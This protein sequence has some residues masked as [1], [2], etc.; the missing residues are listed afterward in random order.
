MAKTFIQDAINKTL[1]P[2]E[3]SKKS[4]QRV[5]EQEIE[6][7]RNELYNMI[8]GNEEAYKDQID[9]RIN[10]IIERLHD[11][12]KSEI[13]DDIEIN[14]HN[15]IP[16][17]TALNKKYNAGKVVGITS[18]LAV[19]LAVTTVACGSK[20][21]TTVE[22]PVE[23]I[24]SIDNEDVSVEIDENQLAAEQ[25]LKQFSTKS[26]ENV[27][28]AIN[29]LLANGIRVVDKD[30][31]EE[32]QKDLISSEWIQYY[33]VA[34][35]DD[36]TTLEYAN[37]MKE[38]PG[39]VLDNDDLIYDFRNMNV[40]MKEQMLVSMPDNKIDFSNLY[41]NENDAKLLNEGADILSRL[42]AAT[43]KAER[44]TISKEFYDYIQNTVLNSTDKLKYSNSAM[45][46]FI[47]VEFSSW[48]EI[49]KNSNF[50]R[51]YYPD[52]ELE[53]KLMTVV[54]NCGMSSGE[55]ANV[56]LE[57]Q[58]KKSLESINV[59]RVLDSLKERKENITNL[60][61]L[62]Q[63]YYLDEAH[64]SNL[65]SE[66]AKGIDLSNYK[67]LE[68]FTEKREK[69]IQNI[70][71]QINKNDSQVSNGQG[72]TIAKDDM[73]ANGINPTDSDAKAK[74]EEAV[75]NNYEETTV[76]KNNSGE[77]ID[78]NQA[79]SWAKQGAI[80]ANNGVKN[81]NVPSLY[82]EA[83]N[84]GWNAA[85]DAKRQAEQNTTTTTTTETVTNGDTTQT[86]LDETYEDF[87]DNMSNDNNGN[88]DISNNEDI[89]SST[90]TKTEFVPVEDGETII[91]E[92][93]EV[94]GFAQQANAQR[95]IEVK[96]LTK[97]RVDSYKELKNL[98]QQAMDSYQEAINIY[99][100]IKENNMSK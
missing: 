5:N 47:N 1:L 18:A 75:K 82:Q 88:N 45:A 60:I 28:I 14:L 65:K 77:V 23:K 38:Q 54:S 48:T 41:N 29:N 43:K 86:T 76:V 33:L 2:Y 78:A 39:A 35:I 89:N 74:Y 30:L 4:F 8:I 85:N 15:D 16:S 52:D 72:G 24:E 90:E 62:G 58:T 9:E 59:I 81:N 79:A 40:L 21:D 94:T 37:F 31:S 92:T 57:D 64:Y 19:V 55:M 100:E 36:I 13:I 84:N 71:P 12:R 20:Q 96:T 70:K 10:K 66:I 44:K 49:T 34:N 93:E 26:T 32:N 99:D 6:N 11:N 22:L 68:S 3:S 73:I 69:E 80:D 56:D 67:E 46:T 7:L 83:Y 25:I 42:N 61:S 95:N 98:L 17:K 51:G 97:N 27:T 50:G 53:A 87:K 91:E 63:L